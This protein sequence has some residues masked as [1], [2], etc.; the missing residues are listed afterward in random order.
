MQEEIELGN[1]AKMFLR[2][3]IKRECWDDMSIKGK[4]VK[5]CAFMLLHVHVLRMCGCTCVCV[6]MCVHACVC[7]CMCVRAC[8][9]ACV[10]VHACVHVYMCACM[11]VC[12]KKKTLRKRR[13]MWL[14]SSCTLDVKEN[15]I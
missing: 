9:R 1:L 7:V 14:V 6:R 4:T 13:S 8:V 2:E 10:C 12:S 3:Q 11:Y 15:C 5:V